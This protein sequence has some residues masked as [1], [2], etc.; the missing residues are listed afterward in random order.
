MA[1]LLCRKEKCPVTP[2]LPE[3][4]GIMPV[5][6]NPTQQTLL[7]ATCTVA[8]AAYS[9]LVVTTQWIARGILFRFQMYDGSYI[10]NDP[11]SR[12]I[13]E[14]DLVVRK[15]IPPG[16]TLIVAMSSTGTGIYAYSGPDVYASGGRSVPAGFFA[17]T[18]S[19]SSLLCF[20][21]APT[22][23]GCWTPAN[24]RPMFAIGF[25]APSEDLRPTCCTDDTSAISGVAPNFPDQWSGAV[26]VWTFLYEVVFPNQTFNPLDTC[27]N[28]EA[29]G[30]CVNVTAIKVRGN[31]PLYATGSWTNLRDDIAQPWTVVKDSY[32]TASRWVPYIT[33]DTSLLRV[34]EKLP[35]TGP[36]VLAA[37]PGQLAV[38][39]FRPRYKNID[40]LDVAIPDNGQGTQYQD[41]GSAEAAF[42]VTSP[43]EP[44]QI[45]YFSV[46]EYNNGI[47]GFGPRYGVADSASFVQYAP[48]FV[49]TTGCTVIPAGTV[50][51][52]TNIGGSSSV[53]G[54][55][56]VVNAHDSGA[57]VGVVSQ[58]QINF[59][60]GTPVVSLIATSQWAQGSLSHPRPWTAEMFV[61]AVLSDQYA[62]DF[63]PL[64]PMLTTP[65][66]R[67]TGTNVYG[68]GKV[69]D[70]AGLPGTVQAA[71]IN[72]AAFTTLVGNDDTFVAPAD[73]PA[74]LHMETFAW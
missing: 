5:L 37:M 17:P 19:G 51:L 63:P 53:N 9:L 20:A 32:Y 46:D 68:R 42:L 21:F 65:R 14:F 4:G 62:G 64:S 45:V 7:N 30:C 56:N 38:V 43:F 23:S 2:L 13:A 3:Q 55:I 40:E 12:G 36:F 34:D 54:P 39:Y 11:A 73:L 24:G 33:N 69:F 48:S 15:D 59:G 25:S 50:V 41:S 57:D 58:I 44:N 10:Y 28:T 31:S 49:W 74:F 47:G 8:D 22:A 1:S 72:S 6:W 35:D 71:L 29:A 16:T 66:T 27:L 70:N 26:K 60:D 61:T 67:M 52:F 18:T